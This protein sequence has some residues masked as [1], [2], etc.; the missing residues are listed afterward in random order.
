MVLMLAE[1]NPRDKWDLI[2]VAA[3][4]IELSK[5]DFER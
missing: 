4:K 5:T 3:A 1:S 2:I